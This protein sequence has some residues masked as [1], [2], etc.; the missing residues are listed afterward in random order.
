MVTR[1]VMLSRLA[2]AAFSPPSTAAAAANGVTAAAATAALEGLTMKAALP[3]GQRLGQRLGQPGHPTSAAVRSAWAAPIERR[4]PGLA[5]PAPPLVG[6]GARGTAPLLASSHGGS[7]G[8]SHDAQWP[9]HHRHHRHRR[10]YHASS[11]AAAVTPSDGDDEDAEGDL[12]GDIEID[13]DTLKAAFNG[14]APEEDDPEGDDLEGDDEG[15]D[16]EGD[17]NGDNAGDFE[18]DDDEYELE[19]DDDEDDEGDD[20]LEATG[21]SS[22]KV[23]DAASAAEARAAVAAAAAAHAEEVLASV[24]P[25]VAAALRRLAGMYHADAAAELVSTAKRS[26]AEASQLLTLFIDMSPVGPD[27]SFLPHY[28]CRHYSCHHHSRFRPSFLL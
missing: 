12:E 5:A 17:L 27:K 16:P 22:M 19:E 24:T 4:R 21:A 6:G 23:R 28:S 11:A 3:L 13:A 2:A 18:L 26:K 20:A 8:F 25:E 14:D 9:N 10:G 7:S 15:Y 1:S